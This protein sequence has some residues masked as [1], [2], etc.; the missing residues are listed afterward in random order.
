MSF[1][2]QFHNSQTSFHP[3]RR[4]RAEEWIDTSVASSS[5]AI[6]HL[7]FTGVRNG[8]YE[9][10][11]PILDEQGTRV[12]F[13]V[14]GATKLGYTYACVYAGNCFWVAHATYAQTMH[15]G[16]VSL[17]EPTGTF[18]L[19]SRGMKFEKVRSFPISEVWA[20]LIWVFKLLDGGA[21]LLYLTQN[22][23]CLFDVPKRELVSKVQF[24][25]FFFREFGFAL[26]PK[27]NLLAIGGSAQGNQDP[28]DGQ[29]RYRNFIR[30]YQL[31]TG[32]V[33]G[34]QTLPGDQETAWHD[35]EFS[36]DGR[37]VRATSSSSSY[38]FDL[39]TS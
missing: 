13:L 24:T 19:A 32:V 11:H 37:Q 29:Y 28:L 30:I 1:K 35:V 8:N 3:A 36:E 27:V 7:R 9:S 16:N 22:G 39:M 5:N 33:V 14:D 17:V 18:L 23:F 4:P 38:I 6:G 34:E 10:K 15:G 21:F 2:I 20:D 12:G 26:S 25:G 31:E